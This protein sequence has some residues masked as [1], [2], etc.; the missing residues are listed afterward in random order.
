[1]TMR[2]HRKFPCFL[3]KKSFPTS[4]CIMYQTHCK[5]Q[6]LCVDSDSVQF[7]NLSYETS[8]EQHCG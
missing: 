8:F 6:Y 7:K 3:Q 4:T 1:M 2:F 5:G